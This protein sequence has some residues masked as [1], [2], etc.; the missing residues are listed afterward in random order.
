MRERKC[1]MTGR[2]KNSKC[3]NVSKS[4]AHT[5]KIQEV[6]LQTKKFFWAEGNKTVKMRLAT[7]TLKT[8]RKLGID[9]T[10]KKY[11]INLNM[12]SVSMG[13]KAAALAGAVSA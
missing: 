3:N 2:R 1:D 11:G 5:H 4:R 8:I 9:A 6:N 12:F 7:K 10:A 13:S